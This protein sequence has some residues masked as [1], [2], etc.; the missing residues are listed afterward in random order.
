MAAAAD[1]IYLGPWRVVRQYADLVDAIVV[2]R[3][4]LGM[5]QIEVDDRAGL[6]LGYMGKLECW[7]SAQYGRSLGVISLPLVL[8]ALGLGLIV[9]PVRKGQ[10]RHHPDERQLTLPLHHQNLY[11]Q[12][13]ALGAPAKL[14]VLP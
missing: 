8:E 10:K 7:R 14:E 12:P 3:K 6:Q 13:A 2:R 9:V 5:S 11:Q 1:D 4:R